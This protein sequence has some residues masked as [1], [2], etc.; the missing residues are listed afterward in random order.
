[1]MITMEP[2]KIYPN[3]NLHKEL[4]AE[5]TAAVLEWFRSNGV[6]PDGVLMGEPVTI[7][8]HIDFWWSGK[9]QHNPDWPTLEGHYAAGDFPR[10][11]HQV[12]VTVPLPDD[13]AAALREIAARRDAERAV[14]RAQLGRAG[15]L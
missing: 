4:P 1:M 10:T 5:Q 15:I 8:T 14:I 12:E 11:H 7:H 2:V 6:D 3:T 9:K 13:L